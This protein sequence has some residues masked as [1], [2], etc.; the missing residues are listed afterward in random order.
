M[1]ASHALSR[2]SVSFHEPNL[3]S[4]AG[5]VPVAELAQRLRVAERIDETVTV[6]GS[7]GANGGAKALTVIGAVLAGGHCIDDV[8]L[9][10]S[11]AL[12]E[13]F[14]RVRA[15]ST[16]GNWLRAMRWGHVRQFDAVARGWLALVGLAYNLGRW[17]AALTAPAGGP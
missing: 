17:C 5:L 4:H 3:V 7:V 11:G 15:P 1:K 12:P 16:V 6:A 8:D 14:D 13:L 9:L 2:V 10:R